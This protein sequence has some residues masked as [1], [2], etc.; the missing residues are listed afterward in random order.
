[1][2][3]DSHGSYVVFEKEVIFHE[4]DFETSEK[5]FDVSKSS[6]WKHTRVLRVGKIFVQNLF[7]K[8]EILFWDGIKLVEIFFAK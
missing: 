3:N 2:R 8:F 6:I 5:D 1:M 4:S 7:D